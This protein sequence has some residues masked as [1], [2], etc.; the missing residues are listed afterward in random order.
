M[1]S[2]TE[3]GAAFSDSG[4]PLMAREVAYQLEISN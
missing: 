3:E 1:V 4:S 2:R